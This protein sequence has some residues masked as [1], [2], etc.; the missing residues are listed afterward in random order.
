[1]M[2]AHTILLRNFPHADVNYYRWLRCAIIRHPLQ[3]QARSRVD[4][5]HW[6]WNFAVR[7]STAPAAGSSY[8]VC[9]CISISTE[10]GGALGFCIREDGWILGITAIG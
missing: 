4:V 9:V 10:E 1:M 2:Y 6:N 7:R 5:R 3:H 8:D